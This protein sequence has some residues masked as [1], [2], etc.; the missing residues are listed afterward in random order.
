VASAEAVTARFA[1]GSLAFSRFG[2]I[3]KELGWIY[4]TMLG[5]AMF[6][7]AI[8]AQSAE[9]AKNPALKPWDDAW[10]C[11]DNVQDGDE[12]GV[13][14]GGTCQP[15][16][17]GE[18]C[19]SAADCQSHHCVHNMCKRSHGLAKKLAERAPSGKACTAL[20]EECTKDGSTKC[21]NL[22]GK[23]GSWALAGHCITKPSTMLIACRRYV[24]AGLLIRVHLWKLLR[25]L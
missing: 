14:C 12:T 9:A 4:S 8:G 18:Y 19:V 13:D 16:K 24:C 11:H 1:L 5:F 3:V 21:D 22:L 6:L 20:A 23:C 17:A 7:L 25:L 2:V 15:C 10:N